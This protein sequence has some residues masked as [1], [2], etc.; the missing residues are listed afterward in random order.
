MKI[1]NKYQFFIVSFLVYLLTTMSVVVFV[2][3]MILLLPFLK[4][5]LVTIGMIAWVAITNEFVRD[6]K[7]LFK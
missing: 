2:G 1:P 3:L 6:F 7:H 5:A 4:A